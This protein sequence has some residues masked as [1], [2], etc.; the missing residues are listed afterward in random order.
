MLA[1]TGPNID[2]KPNAPVLIELII[3]FNSLLY[4]SLIPIPYYIPSIAGTAKLLV[5][6]PATPIIVVPSAITQTSSG[7]KPGNGPIIKIL[8]TYTN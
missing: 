1:P 3:F 4:S 2:P 5:Q 8:I 7:N 6:A